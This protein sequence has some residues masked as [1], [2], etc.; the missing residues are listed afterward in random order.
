MLW[1][2]KA[3]YSKDKSYQNDEV[4]KESVH[5]IYSDGNQ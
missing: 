3:N 1:E 2:E 4:S 5:S